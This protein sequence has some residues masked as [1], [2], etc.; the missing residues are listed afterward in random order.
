VV[1]NHQNSP[2]D[3]HTVRILQPANFLAL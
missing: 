1:L 3:I 2:K